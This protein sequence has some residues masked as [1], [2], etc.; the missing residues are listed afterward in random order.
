MTNQ[1]MQQGKTVP[2]FLS[3]NDAFIQ[4]SKTQ[5]TC[6]QY[7]TNLSNSRICGD[8]G[9]HL[10]LIVFLPVHQKYAHLTLG[11]T[12]SPA[13]QTRHPFQLNL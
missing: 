8:C 5:D 9:F 2:S 11:Y 12:R 1:W 7:R 13:L 10:L 3:Q 6:Y 4:W